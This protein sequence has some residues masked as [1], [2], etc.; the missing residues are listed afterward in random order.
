MK[1]IITNTSPVI[2]DILVRLYAGLAFLLDIL[3][4]ILSPMKKLKIKHIVICA[5]IGTIGYSIYRLFI[6]KPVDFTYMGILFAICLSGG[7]L[8]KLLYWLFAKFAAW[9]QKDICRYYF[10]GARS[11]FLSY[12]VVSPENYYSQEFCSMNFFY[13]LRLDFDKPVQ[14]F[15]DLESVYRVLLAAEHIFVFSPEDDIYK[16][17][18]ME[19]GIDSVKFPVYITN[20]ISDE[21][22][23]VESEAYWIENRMRDVFYNPEYMPHVETFIKPDCQIDNFL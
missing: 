13:E 21:G 7:L 17:A 11:N 16:Q 15:D 23:F 9:V 20:T 4:T 22:D 19:D 3:S 8:I 18:A 10:A 2:I 6:P 5:F 14:C 12:I 1:T